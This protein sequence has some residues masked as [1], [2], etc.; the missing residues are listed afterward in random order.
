MTARLHAKVLQGIRVIDQGTFITGPAA[1]MLL[2]DL[3]ADVIK[4]E[5]PG[6]GDPLRSF[7]GGQCSPH[8]Q[9]CNRNKRSIALDN[10]KE[11]DRRVFEELIASAD[12]YIQNFRPG[13]AERLGAGEEALRAFNPRLVYCAISGFG[14][15]DPAAG[16]PADALTGFYAAYRILG[17]LFERS[18]SGAGR[19]VDVSMLEAMTHFSIVEG[20]RP[21]EG[22]PP[23]LLDE[24]GPEIRAWL[25]SLQY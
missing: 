21:P 10:H 15:D 17:A 13:T 7:R 25:N 14:R 12:V 11:A 20:D 16:R 19:R 3:G 23:P 8:Y 9:A 6:C 5:Q 24:H 22:K 1:G 2:A 4:V 18:V